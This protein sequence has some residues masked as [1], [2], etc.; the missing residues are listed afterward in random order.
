MTSDDTPTNSEPTGPR[1]TGILA[2]LAQPHRAADD[3]EAPVEAGADDETVWRLEADR[4]EAADEGLDQNDSSRSSGSQANGVAA[5]RA[6]QSA[7]NPVELIVE[8]AFDE[9]AR[10]HDIFI[11][12]TQAAVL[13]RK[14]A[15]QAMDDA[16]ARVKP[17]LG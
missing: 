1:R 6:V 11:E 14:P 17:L 15:Q 16:T 5:G 3:Q 10:A 13:G 12:E 2:S 9:Q 8:L 7:Y 4:P